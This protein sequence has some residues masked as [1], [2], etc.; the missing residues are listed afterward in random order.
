ME[1][2]VGQHWF[3]SVADHLGP[4]YL[5]YSFTKGT[6]QE[7]SFLT[8]VLSLEPGS[9]V[10]DVGCG[11]GRHA[12]ALAE[13]GCEVVGV[14][15]SQRFVDLARASA[16]EGATF[17]RMDARA[18]SYHGDFDA[19][20]SLCQGAFGLAGDT[21]ASGNDSDGG[22]TGPP[23]QDGD[24]DV[25]AGIARAVK[26]GGQVAVS[27]FSSYFMV[28]WLEDT[29]TF[30]AS[31]G[32]NH[33]HTE[34]RDESGATKDVELWTTCFTPRELRLLAE[35]VGLVT[36]AVWSVTPGD[37]AARPPTIATPEFLL[38]ARR[39]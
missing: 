37:Y 35:R 14:D 16:P 10:L 39:S 22:T 38:H 13:A 7:V 20:I 5:R 28:R 15:I 31:T 1:P 33:E 11:P 18:L 24:R 21:G 27:A 36:E 6:A 3:E 12:Y 30:D 25:L 2:E 23:A 17:E 8:E 4:A 32:V 34:V 29:D 19:V 9:R 26:P